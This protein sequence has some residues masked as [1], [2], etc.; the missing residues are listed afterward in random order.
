AIA[1]LSGR[2]LL[3][4]EFFATVA[5]MFAMMFRS[6]L[7]GLGGS[8]AVAVLDGLATRHFL[9]LRH[10]LPD[11]QISVLLPHSSPIVNPAG[12]WW[13]QIT[14]TLR[15]GSATPGAFGS[16]IS[17]TFKRIQP[18]TAAAVLGAWLV[19]AVIGAYLVLRARD[20]PQ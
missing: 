17:V 3:G 16:C 2:S 6:S 11:Q 14:G 20:I 5:A 12:P 7:A 19:A 10:Y 8:L 4:M 13:S 1:L 9:F 15:C 18:G